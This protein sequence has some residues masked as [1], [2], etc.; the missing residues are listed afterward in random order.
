MGG[1][2][3]ATVA[4][5]DSL[6]DDYFSYA[7]D[8][9]C[10][11]IYHRWCVIS[12]I[13]ALL[14]RQFVFPHGAFRVYPNVY[15]MLV[16][17]PGS[18]K[19]TAIRLM[20]DVVEPSGYTSFSANKT[21]KEKF[22]V[23][24]QGDTFD[25]KDDNKLDRTFESIF[26]DASKA[27][28]ASMAEPHEVFITIGEFSDF[29]GLGNVEFISLLT[30]LWDNLPYYE[31]RVKNSRSVFIPQPTTNILGGSN[32][33]S[34]TATFPPNII[35]QG[36]LSRLL[37]IFG[38]STGHKI[39][40]PRTPTTAEI[41]RIVGRLQDIKREVRGIATLEPE[42]AD[43]LDIVYKSWR[44]LE[45]VRFKSYSTRRFT[46]LLKLCLIC[47]AARV[48]TS[49]SVFDVTLANTILTF[50]ESLMPKALGE[51]GQSKHSQVAEKIMSVLD[52][53]MEVVTVQQLW[54]HCR[55]DLDR[56]PELASILQG[57]HTA[58]KIQYV[59]GGYLPI[60][61]PRTE[62]LPYVDFELLVERGE[63]S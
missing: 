38:A 29:L 49:I 17:D 40:F 16:G 15:V 37:L 31:S 10:P 59:K 25:G 5:V 53:A 19:D 1:D 24:L 33:A 43:A 45:D 60:K 62:D 32:H 55:T 35:G 52:S 9:E 63:I 56:I 26:G 61:K 46:Y 20:R 39:T 48:S 58:E 36:F 42:A 14:G 34:F 3:L 57:L 47:A 2:L 4:S 13:A 22:L 6:F 18:R 12:G 7:G 28:I 44:D 21:S 8:T 27:D 23:D 51:F 11:A 54:K 50:A 41:A 30:T